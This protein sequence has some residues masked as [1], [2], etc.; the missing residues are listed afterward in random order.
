[1]RETAG[2]T[3]VEDL[4]LGETLEP[5]VVETGGV[6]ALFSQRLGM[7]SVRRRCDWQSEDAGHRASRRVM[8]TTLY[9]AYASSK[10][11]GAAVRAYMNFCPWW[12]IRVSDAA[13]GLRQHPSAAN[14]EPTWS[15]SATAMRSANVDEGSAEDGREWSALWLSAGARTV[16][17]QSRS[18]SFHRIERILRQPASRWSHTWCAARHSGLVL[19][20]SKPGRSHRAPWI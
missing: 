16:D 5:G 6:L 9:R 14:T 11:I 15:L 19:A 3:A 10:Q 7:T 17:V 20:T 4:V 12:S 8:V 18:G 13:R 1:M 2:T